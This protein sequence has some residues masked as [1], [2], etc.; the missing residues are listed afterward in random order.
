[1]KGKIMDV[2]FGSLSKM[3]S[4]Q[5]L[6]AVKKY[7]EIYGSQNSTEN[8]FDTENFK[9]VAT[10]FFKS[11]NSSS[12][13]E[14]FLQYM[15]EQEN[16]TE[17]SQTYKRTSSMQLNPRYSQNSENN[18]I[19]EETDS[20]KNLKYVVNDDGKFEFV[21]NEP[22]KIDI[23]TNKDGM[24]VAQKPETKE[25]AE[26]EKELEKA[27]AEYD[28]EHPQDKPTDHVLRTINYSIEQREKREQFIDDFSN[29]YKSENPEFAEQYDA[30]KSAVDDVKQKNA[31]KLQESHESDKTFGV[32]GGGLFD[33]G[34]DI[35]GGIK[36]LGSDIVD[37]IKETA[38]TF[39][40]K[41]EKAKSEIVLENGI[42]VAKEP[43][44]EEWAEYKKELAEALAEY[45]ENHPQSSSS[46]NVNPLNMCMIFY[47]KEGG[48]ERAK[49][50]E[51]FTN[52]YKSTH[53]E[54]AEQYDDYK[55]AQKRASLMM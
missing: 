29:K 8:V 31:E 16:K 12:D 55:A 27:L 52:V 38:S 33:I 43:E 40:E 42:F 9:E 44:T 10:E 18:K 7:S 47:D 2:S 1:M 22:F 3:T 13:D 11:Q 32:L 41:M 51:S 20:L 26:Y 48:E 4:K 14:N 36:E 25:W 15:N 39:A 54:F 5:A 37:G 46:S 23:T 28:K 49:F 45:D 34:T 35:L 19:A 30:Y 24:Y 6:E 17:S 53:P 21:E 50:I